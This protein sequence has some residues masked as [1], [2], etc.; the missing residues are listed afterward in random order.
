MVKITA[1]Q[2]REIY[3]LATDPKNRL[4]NCAIA[5][6][7]NISEGAV[8]YVIKRQQGKLQK[9]QQTNVDAQQALANISLNVASEAADLIAQVK[10]S[11]QQAKAEGETVRLASL[12]SN[13][14][15]ALELAC[16]L[17]GVTKPQPIEQKIVAIEIIAPPGVTERGKVIEV[18]AERPRQEIMEGELVTMEQK[19][20]DGEGGA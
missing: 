11:I 16:Q 19:Q 13:W 6:K 14:I 3:R 8:R 15:K 10:L 2:R 12:Y 4:T 5:R 18:T 1:E 7:Y 20:Q 9:L 17:L